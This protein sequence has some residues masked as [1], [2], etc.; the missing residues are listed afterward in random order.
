[1][2]VMGYP[3][4]GPPYYGQ[5]AAVAPMVATANSQLPD[6]NELLRQKIDLEQKYR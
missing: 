1:M 2:P 3:G 4:G 5:P 6:Y